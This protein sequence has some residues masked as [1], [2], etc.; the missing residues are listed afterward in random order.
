[1]PETSKEIERLSLEKVDL[2]PKPKEDVMII[3]H[4]LEEERSKINKE[5]IDKFYHSFV[6]RDNKAL[7]KPNIENVTEMIL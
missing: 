3:E 7:E 6:G 2:K 1:M 4:S 5:D